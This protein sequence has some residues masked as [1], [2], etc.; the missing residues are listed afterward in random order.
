MADSGKSN[1][2]ALLALSPVHA[3]ALAARMLILE[4]D[5]REIERNL[6]GFH[7]ILYEYAGEIP[8]AAKER[9][10]AILA[11]IL[12]KLE[13]ISLELGLRKQVV[14]LDKLIESRLSRIWVTLHES[15]SRGL[16][17]YGAVPEELKAY[18]DP[19]MDGILSLLT[20]LRETLRE[21]K[22]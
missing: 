10:R 1:S 5:C 20:Q 8:E 6:D 21:T 12:D 3:G 9:L 2:G 11:E 22:K 15:K 14:E 18:L 16:R 7:G 4:E 13:S 17:G 19:R